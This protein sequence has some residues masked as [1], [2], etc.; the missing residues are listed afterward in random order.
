M[1][2][3]N[4]RAHYTAAAFLRPDRQVGP[5]FGVQGGLFVAAPGGYL[6]AGTAVGQAAI[7]QGTAMGHWQQESQ[8]RLAEGLQLQNAAAN[9]RPA[10]L[11]MPGGPDIGGAFAAAGATGVPEGVDL[12]A[13][14][15]YERVPQGG[16]E[17]PIVPAAQGPGA[18]V[19]QAQIAAMEGLGSTAAPKPITIRGPEPAPNPAEA[20]GPAPAPAPARNP[21]IPQWGGEP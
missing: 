18:A 10:E 1:R 11:A 14:P 20:P 9:I 17:S 6:P 2:C 21:D 16:P 15:G 8:Q 5:T 7:E 3:S 19:T 12:S 4:R 13:A